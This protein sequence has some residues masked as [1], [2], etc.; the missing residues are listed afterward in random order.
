MSK[1]IVGVT[2]GIGAGKSTVASLFARY[3]AGLVDTDAISRQMTAP[4][5]AAIQ[6]IR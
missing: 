6:A 3:G 2:G 1:F 5:G 4:G